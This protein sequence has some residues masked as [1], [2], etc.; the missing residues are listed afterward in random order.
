MKMKFKML[1]DF[2]MTIGLLFLMSYQITGEE[3]HEYLGATMLI[4]FIIHNILNFR[5]YKNLTK[6]KFDII[7]ILKTIINIS[8]FI[9]MIL[10]G[11]S[12][13]V[14]SRYL[15]APLKLNGP[16]ATARGMHL[17]L[18]YWGFLLMSFH[19][20]MHWQ[21]IILMSKKVF[22]EKFVNIFLIWILRIISISVAIFGLYVF[23]EKQI[24][25]YMLYKNQFVFFDYDKNSFLIFLEN[26][27]MMW[28][29]V[30]IS[31][32]ITKAI[33][34]I[35]SKIGKGKEFEKN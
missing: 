13:I 2:L 15:F 22:K 12:G 5:W 29:F 32:Y 34:K 33:E 11:F 21:M 9:I 30:F 20:G 25:D 1:I 7:R 35:S 24:F 3:F 18:S 10:M 8:L 6:G 16:L 27:S 19:L 14:L 23:N 31:Y 4:L 28:A 26:L 17:V